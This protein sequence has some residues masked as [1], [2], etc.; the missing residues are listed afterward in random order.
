M[1]ISSSFVVSTKTDFFFKILVSK[2]LLKKRSESIFV[3]SS[4]TDFD[5]KNETFF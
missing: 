4:S 1:F 5:K 2:I 3:C